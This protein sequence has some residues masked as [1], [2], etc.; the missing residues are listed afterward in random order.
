MKFQIIFLSASQNSLVQLEEAAKAAGKG[1][2][3]EGAS[4]ANI[5]NVTWTIENPRNFVDSHHNK[6]IDGKCLAQ[7]QLCHSIETQNINF[8]GTKFN[9]QIRCRI[10]FHA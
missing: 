6:P 8:G 9:I 4:N 3:A 2:W 5:R 1:K 7:I 10:N